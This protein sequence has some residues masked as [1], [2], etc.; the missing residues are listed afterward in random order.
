M[1]H[2][3]E[4]P[5]SDGTYREEGTT[6]EERIQA[7]EKGQAEMKSRMDALQEYVNGVCKMIDKKG[8]IDKPFAKSEI[9]ANYELD[10]RD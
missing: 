1:G 5:I 9:A 10:P 7:L 6:N 3:A 2:E 4:C 8:L